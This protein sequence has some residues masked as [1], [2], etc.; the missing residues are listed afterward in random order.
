VLASLVEL[1]A[2]NVGEDEEA[3]RDRQAGSDYLENQHRHLAS[4]LSCTAPAGPV[5]EV[6]AN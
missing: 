2:D 5:I 3:S 6:Y 4:L 1:P